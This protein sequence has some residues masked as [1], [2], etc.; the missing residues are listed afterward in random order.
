M[1]VIVMGMRKQNHIHLRYIADWNT[2]C[3]D[4]ALKPHTACP[5]WIRDEIQASI[6]NQKCSVTD[7]GYGSL[8]SI[9]LQIIQLRGRIRDDIGIILLLPAALFPPLPELL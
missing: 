8:C 2:W 9:L 6:L 7:P 4:P 1:H 5:Y 3:S